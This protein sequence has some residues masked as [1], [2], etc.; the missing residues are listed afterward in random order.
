MVRG[1]RCPGPVQA[2]SLRAARPRRGD[3]ERLD[4]QHVRRRVEDAGG[5]PDPPPG[6]L[7]LRDPLPLGAC[8]RGRDGAVAPRPE[9]CAVVWS[10]GGGRRTRPAHEPRVQHAHPG[11]SRRWREVGCQRGRP[12][13]WEQ[14]GGVINRGWT[15]RRRERGRHRECWWSDGS[16][17]ACRYGGCRREGRRRHREEQGHLVAG[18]AGRRCR[19]GFHG[20]EPGRLRL[21]PIRCAR[22]RAGARGLLRP[23]CR[24]RIEPSARCGGLAFVGRSS[25]GCSRPVTRDRTGGVVTGNGW[26]GSAFR[27][28]GPPDRAASFAEWWAPFRNRAA[29]SPTRHEARHRPARTSS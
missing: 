21:G 8:F 4:R 28:T 13:R 24:V 17:R 2:R 6:C 9:E 20:P 5:R 7:R 11:L 29:D 18:Y 23:G 16:G 10:G 26:I 19:P 12:G 1:H 14:G 25:C 22:R 27:A 3:P 15:G